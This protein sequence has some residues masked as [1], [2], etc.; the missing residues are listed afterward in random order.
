MHLKTRILPSH[1][2]SEIS[3]KREFWGSIGP[4]MTSFK[5]SK[6][7]AY[8]RNL[9]LFK[10]VGYKDTYLWKYLQK[11]VEEEVYSFFFL[12]KI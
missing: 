4:I 10:K 8:H 5:E 1:F 6:R 12:I 9:W 2:Q 3:E 11:C 7:F